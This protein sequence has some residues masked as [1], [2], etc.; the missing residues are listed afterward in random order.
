MKLLFTKFFFFLQYLKSKKYLQM[1]ESPDSPGKI[2][3]IM[4]KWIGDT[5]WDLQGIPAL[6][7]QFPNAEIHVIT[8]PFSKFLFVHLLPE[9]QI[10]V[11]TQILSDCR[12]ETFHLKTWKQ[13]LALAESIQ[14]DLLI[15]FTET[16]FSAVFSALCGAKS[17]AG[18]DHLGR[19]S[20]LYTFRVHAEYGLHLSRRP[21]QLYL[22]FLGYEPEFPQTVPAVPHPAAP[23]A[24]IIIF[25]GTGWKTKEYPAEKYHQIA[26]I[27][28][29][30]G[31]SICVAGSRKEKMLCET[32]ADGLKN[33]RI[34]CGSP[35]EMLEH[36]ASA[37][38]CLSGDTGPAHLAAAMGLFTV[39]LFCGTNPEFCGPRG[40]NVLSLCASCPDAPEGKTQFCPADRRFAC[41]RTCFMNIEQD[42][43]LSVILKKLPELNAS[44]SQD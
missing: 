16:P 29:E 42:K 31:F 26:K 35:E 1:E 3:L 6:Q 34:Q 25:P 32:V 7:K 15:D 27:L 12:R 24:D 18:Y 40:K 8:K 20:N 17:I 37:K 14:P 38:V 43:V 30:K 28:S 13:E 9:S 39:T 4:C 22:P 2:L 41:E 21:M 11:S 19:F 5:F 10:H 33:V 23:G 44:R 36:L